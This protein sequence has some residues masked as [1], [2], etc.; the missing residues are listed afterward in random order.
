[1]AKI[2]KKSLVMLMI[3][4]LTLTAWL[5]IPQP[6][7]LTSQGWQT[8]LIFLATITGLILNPFPMGVVTFLALVSSIVTGSIPINKALEGFGQNIVWLVI[9][10]FF[11]ARTVINTGLGTRIAYLFISRFGK[12]PIGV[13]YSI[14][15]T[16]FCIAPMIPSATSRG[17]GI[18]YPIAKSA[19][20]SYISSIN[21]GHKKIGEFFTMICL[22]SNI[23]T[24][25]MFLTAMAGNPV[26]QKIATG[27]GVEITWS[28]WAQAAVVPGLVSLILLPLIV[29][30]FCRMP[31]GVDNDAIVAAAKDGLKRLGKMTR[32]ELI[33]ASTFI[34][35]ITLWVL[36]KEV[37][38]NATT[39]AMLGV[40]VLLLTGVLTWNDII[41]EKSAWDI[42]MWFS[43]LVTIANSLSE[44]NVTLWIGN[45]ISASL[46]GYTALFTGMIVCLGLFFGH[47]MFASTTVYFTAMYGV[48]LKT[49]LNLG[50]PPLASAYSLIIVIMISSGFTHYG[51]SSAPVF[52]S[53]GY[54]TVKEWWKKSF[55]ITVSVA[56]VWVAICTTWW[57]II[58]WI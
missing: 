42:F 25:T 43:I 49:F 5:V 6:S 18:I 27:L 46:N 10:A 52:F 26:A 50:L 37:G 4:V 32:D 41:N 7:Q 16:E 44:Q 17:G 35:L 12:T 1:M 2:N 55:F 33:T 47:Y 15:F 56:I 8:F 31:V 36:E 39:T 19:I 51:I 11:I 45:I 22:H 40:S 24:S 21:H 58:G 34:G 48:F 57:S 3:A 30:T 29:R 38:I 9:C 13:A 28:N 53:G 20:E 14:I 23:I 54:M